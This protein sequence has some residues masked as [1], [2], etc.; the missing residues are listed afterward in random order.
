ME[1]AIGAGHVPPLPRPAG[2]GVGGEGRTQPIHAF[3]KPRIQADF[4]EG[5]PLF[6]AKSV[7]I[8]AG[9]DKPG[10]GGRRESVCGAGVRPLDPRP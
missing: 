6:L 8:G 10:K 4:R 1:R 9:A 7:F 2:E 3:R 5:V